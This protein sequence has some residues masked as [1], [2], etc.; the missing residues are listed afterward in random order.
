M[1]ETDKKWYVLRAISGKEAKVKEY[2]E[3]DIKNSG[4]NDFISQVLIPTEKVYQVRNGKKVLVERSYLP[5]YVLIEAKLVG[6]VI[7][8][9]VNTPNVINFLGGS[10]NPVP[11]RQSEV[12]RILGTVDELQDGNVDFS[13]PFT[14]GEIVKVNDG[15][16]SGFNGVIEEVNNEKKKLKVMVKI[17]GRKTP[18]ELGFTQVDK[19]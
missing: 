12:S 1:S 16:F 7:H 19:E 10:D 13:I 4:L 15:P 14:V 18:L 9:L 6:E 11:L 17:F 3:A 2:L 8:H 5:G